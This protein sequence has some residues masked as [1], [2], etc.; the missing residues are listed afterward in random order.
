MSAYDLIVLGGGPA[1]YLAS[2]RAGHAG[3]RVLCIEKKNV[4]GVCLRGLYTHKDFA[5]QRQALRRRGVWGKYGVFVKDANFDHKAVL[6]RKKK[7]IK[8]LSGGIKSTLK[9]NGVELISGTGVIC[10]RENDESPFII[11]V[12]SD[13]YEG[14]R[15]LVGNRLVAC[16]AAYKG[17]RGRP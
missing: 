15:L 16:C 13:I 14:T 12:G 5:V 11:S 10:S 8:L 4:G 1:G 9:A 6:N 7:V 2:E 17:A 3:L